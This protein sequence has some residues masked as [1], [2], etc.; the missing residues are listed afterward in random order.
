[1]YGLIMIVHWTDIIVSHTHSSGQ[2]IATGCTS[3][4]QDC[5]HGVWNWA[6]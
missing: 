3:H 1:M 6:G 4:V 5:K 2:D